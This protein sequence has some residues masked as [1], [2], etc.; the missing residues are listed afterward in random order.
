M[1]H[2]SENSRAIMGSHSATCHPQQRWNF[3]LYPSQ[4]RLVLDLATEN[5]WTTY[6][7]PVVIRSTASHSLSLAVSL[8][9]CQTNR[10]NSTAMPCNAVRQHYGWARAVAGLI[11][12]LARLRGTHYRMSSEI[13]KI[14]LTVSNGPW[15]HFCSQSINAYQRIRGVFSHNALY[16]ST[17]YITLHYI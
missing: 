1:P 9:S 16:K 7:S 13:R 12:S 11:L 6:L 4:L 2:R 8:E 10:P 3:R 5:G 15:R 17:Y 14:A